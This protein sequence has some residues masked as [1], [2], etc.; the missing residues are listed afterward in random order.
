MGDSRSDWML[1]ERVRL[2][3]VQSFAVR[4]E[5]EKCGSDEASERE[6]GEVRVDHGDRPVRQRVQVLRRP[7]RE[8]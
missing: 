7:V 5:R 3:K 1:M 2:S 6:G 8:S 4:R